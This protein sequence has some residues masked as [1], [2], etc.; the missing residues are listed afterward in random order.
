MAHSDPEDFAAWQAGGLQPFPSYYARM[1]PAN[2]FGRMPMPATHAPKGDVDD[3]DR[4][5]TAA[6]LIDARAVTP[7]SPVTSPART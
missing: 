4:L 2:L 5:G 1:G 3:L 6:E 7:R